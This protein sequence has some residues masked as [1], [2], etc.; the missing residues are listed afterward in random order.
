MGKGTSKASGGSS[1]SGGTQAPNLNKPG[2]YSE[3]DLQQML[4]YINKNPEEKKELLDQLSGADKR[5]IADVI[6]DGSVERFSRYDSD[7]TE[8]FIN[9][10]NKTFS[11]SNKPQSKRDIQIQEL[12]RQ[13]KYGKAQTADKIKVGDT[14]DGA[15]YTFNDVSLAPKKTTS[16]WSG[17]SYDGS[18]TVVG[19]DYSF[20]VKSVKKVK[21][22]VEITAEKLGGVSGTIVKKKIKNGTYLHVYGG[23]K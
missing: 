21:D 19:A 9:Q 23:S 2:M 17:T 20:K 6:S 22:G 16:S 15:Q 1:G 11:K 8:Q 13:W 14:I 18:K 10:Y 3:N 5:S 7:I 4:D 12:E